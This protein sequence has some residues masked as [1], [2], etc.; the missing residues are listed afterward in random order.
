[1][2]KKILGLV[3]TLY[4]FTSDAQIQTIDTI[5]FSLDT[6]LLVFKASINDVVVNFAFDTGATLG[7]SNSTIQSSTGLIVKNGSQTITDANLKK[8][9][10]NNTV[11]KKMQIGSHLIENIKGA[12]YDMEFLTCHQLYLLGMDVIGKLNWKID[13]KHQQLLVSKSPFSINNNLIEI[14]VSNISNRP[15]TSLVING[16][17]YPDCLIDLGYTGSIEI[18]EN[19]A[20]NMHYQ[21]MIGTGRTEIGLNSNMSV[22]GLGKPDTVK[23]I[24][25]DKFKIG[26]IDLNNVNATIYE[27]TKF[28]I[29]IG[30]FSTQTTAIILNHTVGK[31][32]IE[33]KP[34]SEPL[35]LPL[36]ARV[37][38]Q[39][40]LLRITAINLNKNSSAKQLSIGETIKSINGKQASD[41]ND[42]CQFFLEFFNPKKTSLQIEKLDGTLVTI[43]RSPLE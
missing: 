39:D 22:T 6:K 41:F 8:I 19:A 14:P 17:N 1:M 3:L 37:S 35:L 34:N 4:S 29:G 43:L 20:L 38:Y 42:N 5:P 2:F 12:I 30:F 21:Q 11:I 33:P 10:I 18:P 16:I 24:L 36:D 23:T 40:G 31:Y 15:K 7:L 26:D 9:K 27:K 25:M 13:F 28:K 32:Y